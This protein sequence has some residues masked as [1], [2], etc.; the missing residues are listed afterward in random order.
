MGTAPRRDRDRLPVSPSLDEVPARG[1][2]AGQRCL[3][4]RDVDRL[5]LSALSV[6]EDA[7]PRVLG[8]GD[9]DGIG[10]ARGLLGK[11]GCVWPSDH[12]GHAAAAEPPGEVV[13]VQGGRRRRSDPHEVRRGVEPHRLDDLV[14]V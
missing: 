14:R 9:D 1:R 2:H 5:E 11:S 13:G 8:L 4:T 6:V 3:P 10:V 12:D 7:R